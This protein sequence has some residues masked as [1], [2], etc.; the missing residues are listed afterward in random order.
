M[1]ILRTSDSIQE[2]SKP[3]LLF[4]GSQMETGG[5]QRVLLTQAEWFHK[6]G[7]RVV[8][9]FLYDKENLRE[10]W[11]QQY[12]FPVVDLRARVDHAGGLK[13]F[14]HL[15][16]GITRLVKL[17]SMQ[18]FSG[19]ETF[20]HHSNLIGLPIASAARIPVR[21]ASHHGRINEFPSWLEGLHTKL[22]NSRLT[23]SL[24]V[25]SDGVYKASIEEGIVPHKIINDLE[26]NINT[27]C[28]KECL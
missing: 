28:G 20:T 17:I 16:G 27:K 12:D 21:I 4:L 9:A 19:I 22:I 2:G 18:N 5:A 8:A 10:K 26:R 11:A 13:N 23:T 3:G 7:Y 25:V 15:L 1:H 6:K 14:F 24:V